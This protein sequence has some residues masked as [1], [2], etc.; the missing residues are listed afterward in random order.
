M[1]CG[2]K[3]SSTL[4]KFYNF[5]TTV[6]SFGAT[7]KSLDLWRQHSDNDEVET[8][9]SRCTF[10]SQ[11]QTLLVESTP[12]DVQVKTSNTPRALEPKISLDIRGSFFMPKITFA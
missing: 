10:D 5:L 3:N 4:Q 7:A 6:N 12:V 2:R 11:R 8:N 9:M 1:K